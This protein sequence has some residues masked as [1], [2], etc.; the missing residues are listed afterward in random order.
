M[1]SGT[2]AASAA[3]AAAAPTTTPAKDTH[4]LAA[5]E[6]AAV[7]ATE[8]AATARRHLKLEQRSMEAAV[9]SLAYTGNS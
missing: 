1:G 9:G 8:P 7:A 2:A 6:M 3:A 5:M 4:S